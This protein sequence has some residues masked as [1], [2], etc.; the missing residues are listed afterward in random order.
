MRFKHIFLKIYFCFHLGLFIYC[1]S[2]I[3]W[4]NIKY[5]YGMCSATA[6]MVLRLTI[7][8]YWKYLSCNTW[9]YHKTC[10]KFKMWHGDS[11]RTTEWLRLERTFKD[12]LVQ[13]PIDVNLF[14]PWNLTR[15]RHKRRKP[16]SLRIKGDYI[17]LEF[18]FYLH[19]NINHSSHFQ[20]I[21]SLLIHCL[22]N[23]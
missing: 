17:C 10:I 7:N 19:W 4:Y 9:N 14:K 23:N 1:T 13:L 21:S 8:L 22:H 11:H 16:F 3:N 20:I 6:I 12:H 5:N 2:W 18:I 15:K